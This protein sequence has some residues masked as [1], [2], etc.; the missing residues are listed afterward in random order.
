MQLALFL[1]ERGQGAPRQEDRKMRS[2]FA[3]ILGIVI[4]GA[5]TMAQRAAYDYDRTVNFAAFKSY[6]WIPGTNLADELNHQRVQ[7]AIDS[8]LVAHGL[9]RAKS[10]GDAD[11]L[12]AYHVSFDRNLQIT[13]FGGA[14]AGPRFGGYRSGTATTQ[15][16]V[17]G[18]LVIDILDAGTMKIVW[19]GMA[20]SEINPTASPETRDKN[21]GRAVAR[22]FRTY[23]QKVVSDPI[24]AAAR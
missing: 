17:S 21:I 24:A 22:I 14:W 23:P 4:L 7:R 11:I 20:S 5:V 2:A 1:R 19:R 13:A 8:Q 18:T 3:T 10:P 12:V 15:Q 6:A 9:R 16:I